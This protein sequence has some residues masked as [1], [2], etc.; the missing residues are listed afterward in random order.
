MQIKRRNFLTAAATLPLAATVPSLLSAKAPFVTDQ[1]PGV[2]RYKVG[3]LEV[4]AL[5]DGFL[6]SGFETLSPYDLATHG[7][8]LALYGKDKI[9]TAYRIPVSAF[10][11]NTGEKLVLIDAGTPEGALPDAGLIT[12][13]LKAAGYT[14]DQVDAIYMTHLHVD[15]FGALADASGAA[16]FPNAELYVAQEEW[17]FWY[18]DA[19]RAASPADGRVWFDMA[20]NVTAPYKDRLVTFSGETDLGQGISTVPLPGHTSGHTG[21]T[22]N[23]GDE[24]L[25]IWGDVI[26]AA[27]IQFA[28]PEV[29]VAFD[30][31]MDTARKTRARVLDMAAA[32]KLHVSGMHLDFPSVGQVVREGSAYRYQADPWAYKL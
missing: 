3:N 23:S 12:L 7:D 16:Y 5:L 2:Y 8:Q 31:D 13:S 20:R 22:L 28:H 14:P 10:L 15:H 32:D 25:L 27:G 29:G 21:F 4:T 9:P 1:V 11:V 26:H 19:I 18:D 17:N 6:D 24:S 30:I